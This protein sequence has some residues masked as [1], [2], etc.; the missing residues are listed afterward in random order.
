M[1]LLALRAPTV[2]PYGWWRIDQLE[3][4]LD[5]ITAH[6]RASSSTA[7]PTQ[8]VAI[9]WRNAA[10]EAEQRRRALAADQRSAGDPQ[11]A[12][13]DKK[14]NKRKRK[15]AAV[16]SGS[17]IGSMKAFTDPS[18][19]YL[20]TEL[21]SSRSRIAALQINDHSP[22]LLFDCFLLGKFRK[23]I[24]MFLNVLVN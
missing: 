15:A 12:S 19:L 4:D 21:A 6:R 20:R 7:Q 13:L 16:T 24:L 22:D 8:T 11:R 14:Y 9:G 5:L 23:L 2:G 17:D 3:V 18:D 1:G 10:S